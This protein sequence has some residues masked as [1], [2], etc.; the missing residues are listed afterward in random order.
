MKHLC[1]SRN[2]NLKTIN[3]KSNVANTHTD[4]VLEMKK[5]FDYIKTRKQAWIVIVF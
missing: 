3:Q 5:N 2:V 1:N 4:I